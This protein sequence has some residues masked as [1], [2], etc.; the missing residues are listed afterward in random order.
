MDQ[1]HKKITWKLQTRAILSF[2]ALMSNIQMLISLNV[3]ILTL[4]HLLEE[5]LDAVW[6]DW[7]ATRVA[8]FDQQLS[9]PILL[10][11]R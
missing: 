8:S 4:R 6:K 2:A 1:Y 9:R 5:W 11:K 7:N 10:L 3:N